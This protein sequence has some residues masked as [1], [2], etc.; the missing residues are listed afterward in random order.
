MHS[1]RFFD[2]TVYFLYYK[3]MS[4]FESIKNEFRIPDAYENWSSYRKALTDI[5]IGND[6]IEKNHTK[7]KEGYI[8]GDTL[9]NRSIAILGAGPCNDIDLLRVHEEYKQITLMDVDDKGMQDA[10][11]RYGLRHSSGISLKAVSLTGLTDEITES[12]FNRLYLYIVD[13]GKNLTEADFQERTLM[14]FKEVEDKLYK[15]TR[16]FSMVLPE[17]AYDTVVSVGL[18]SQ[19][20]SVLSYSWHI[21]AGNVSEQLLGGRPVDPDPFHDHLRDVDDTF[22][23][24]MNTAIL[25][26]SKHRVLFSSEYDPN[27][28]S[29]GAWQCIKDVRKRYTGG[30]IELMESTLEWPFFPEQRRKYTMLIQDIKLC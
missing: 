6:M 10:L 20:W 24:M 11:D 22:I 28:P 30:E 26:A 12:F 14:E 21:L 23:P 8:D 18:H 15:N 2:F 25:Q 1:F 13:R 29:E 3:A 9:C 4:I 5:I 19:L 17:A 27:N 16:D 7:N